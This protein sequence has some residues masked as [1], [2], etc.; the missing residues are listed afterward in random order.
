MYS[1]HF[2]LNEHKVTDLLITFSS[3]HLFSFSFS[4]ILSNSPTRQPLCKLILIS[5]ILQAACIFSS[6]TVDIV[7]TQL[8]H[9]EGKQTQ[10]RSVRLSSDS[11]G[12]SCFL[13]SSKCTFALCFSLW[14]QKLRKKSKKTCSPHAIRKLK[15]Q[16]FQGH[17]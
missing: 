7:Y 13:S 15:E 3:R 14:S 9:L 6:Q 10:E 17:E 2:S 16:K 1:Q 12:H 4:R 8:L 5:L 11:T